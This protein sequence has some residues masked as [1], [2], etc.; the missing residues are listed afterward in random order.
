MKTFGNTY[1]WLK[2]AALNVYSPVLLAIV[3]E[4]LSRTGILNPVFFPPPSKFLY[5]IY[6]L[7]KQGILAKDV[8]IS[9][10]RIFSGLALGTLP[11]VI[12]GILS[13][14]SKK[15]HYFL[16]PLISLTYPIP[17]IAIIPFLILFLGIGEV[18]K[19]VLVA[20]GAFF[21]VFINTYHGVSHIDKRYFDAARIYALSRTDRWIYIVI[22]ASLPSIFNGLKLATG[23]CFVLVVAAEFIGGTKGIGYRIWSSWENFN[24]TRM[25]AAL[26]V[27]AFLGWGMNAIIEQLE[28]LS[29]PWRKR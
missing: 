26:T 12:L 3:W 7:F 25:L 21:L 14:R 8:S 15:A 11:G 19:I 24:V 13:A 17:K 22:P 29:M 18:S 28:E 5:E 20:L 1:R 2:N 16:H 9:L 27:L 23:M 4:I 6:S 10:F